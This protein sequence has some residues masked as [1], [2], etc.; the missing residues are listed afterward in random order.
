MTTKGVWTARTIRHVIVD[1]SH[2]RYFDNE[3]L[4]KVFRNCAPGF[5]LPYPTKR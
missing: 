4:M 3:R 5:L 1:A 2:A